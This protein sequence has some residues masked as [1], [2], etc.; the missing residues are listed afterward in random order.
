MLR[1]VFVTGAFAI[2]ATAVAGAATVAAA[3]SC[4]NKAN[5]HVACTD[6]LTATPMQ[7][8]RVGPQGQVRFFVDSPAQQP[9]SQGSNT[10]ARQKK[11]R[12]LLPAVQKVRPA[13]ERSSSTKSRGI[14]T[15]QTTIIQDM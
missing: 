3:P 14:P 10:S 15:R 7:R 1:R 13:A 6:R 4:K 12:L 5:P 9:V 2:F 11:Q 8:Q